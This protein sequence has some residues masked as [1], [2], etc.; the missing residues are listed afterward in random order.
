MV[1]TKYKIK[2]K[3]KR[4]EKDLPGLPG[5]AARREAHHLSQQQPMAQRHFVAQHTHV[6]LR[7]DIDEKTSSSSSPSLDA[8]EV[9]TAT[10]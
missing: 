4:G 8:R 7:V 3:K 5:R 2:Q 6:P 1:N 9:D 10:N